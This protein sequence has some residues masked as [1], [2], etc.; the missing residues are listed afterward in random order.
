MKNEY[1]WLPVESTRIAAIRYDLKE[2]VLEVAFKNGEL[3]EHDEV[4]ANFWTE[5]TLAKSI[6]KYYFDNIRKTFPYEV[7]KW[8]NEEN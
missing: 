6:G 8:E 2:K 3:Y 4:P 7:L 5:M 1:E